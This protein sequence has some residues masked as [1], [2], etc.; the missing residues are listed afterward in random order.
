MLASQQTLYG[1]SQIDEN[2]EA[3][4]NL[5][6]RWCSSTS[7]LGIRTGP[8]AADDLD[9]SLRSQPLGER[10]GCAVGQ[11]VDRSMTLVIDQHRAIGAALL[12]RPVIHAHDPR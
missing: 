10:V 2:V 7:A 11:Q 1:F 4:S 3:V 9:P 6:R 12:P 5:D 8:I